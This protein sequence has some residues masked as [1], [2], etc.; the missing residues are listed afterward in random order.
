M[1]RGGFFSHF[2]TTP[3]GQTLVD[4][5]RRSHYLPARRYVVGE[6]LAYG[7]GGRSTPASILRAWM[8][9][10]THRA[11][12]LAPSFREVG[13]GIEPGSPVAPK[14]GVTYTTDFGR[15]R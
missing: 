2:G 11:N 6:N 8:H 15:R 14:R 1:I 3:P 5:L 13:I 9:S 7:R 12:I 4:R 10:T